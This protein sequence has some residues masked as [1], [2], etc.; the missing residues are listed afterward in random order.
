MSEPE[1]RP[2]AERFLASLAAL[3][4][5]PRRTFRQVIVGTFEQAV[6]DLSN[7]DLDVFGLQPVPDL[8]KG[9]RLVERARSTCLFV[10][11]SDR[12]SALA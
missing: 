11:D 3:A 9:R 2:G 1:Q 10:L 4:R 6:D 8:D 5:L 7:A 12:E